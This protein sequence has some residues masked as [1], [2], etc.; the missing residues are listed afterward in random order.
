MPV[1]RPLLLLGFA[2][3]LAVAGCADGDDGGTDAAASATTESTA[4][5]TSPLTTTTTE[6]VDP[7]HQEFC[8]AAGSQLASAQALGARLAG[9]I[10]GVEAAVEELRASNADVGAAA[11]EV[12]RADVALV[13]GAGQRYLDILERAGFDRDK[14][15]A[16]T[17]ATLQTAEVRGAADREAAYLE[18]ECGLNVDGSP[19]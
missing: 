1:P 14:V 19:R 10:E 18:E 7:S 17:L 4:P 11:P 5:P 15:P 8:L 3:C 12:I 13:V 9:P 16:D 2:L 6:P